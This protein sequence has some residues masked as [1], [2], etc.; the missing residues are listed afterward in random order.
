MTVQLA[1]A[2]GARVIGTASETGH[3]Y[4]RQ[5]GA[6]PVAYGDGL[7]D[8]VRDLAPG[9]VDAAIDTVGTD[10][11]IDVSVALVADRDRIATLAA[12]R[13]GLELGLRVL[14]GAPGADPGIEVRQAARLRAGAPGRGGNPLGAGGGHLPAGLGG[15]RPP[16]AGR[17]P[18]PRED[19]P[20]PLRPEPGRDGARRRRAPRCRRRPKLCCRDPPGPAVP[21]AAPA[22]GPAR[23]GA[24]AHRALAGG[25]PPRRGRP[26]GGH[27]RGV[28]SER[29]PAPDLRGGGHPPWPPG[30]RA[31]RRPAAPVGQAGQ[32]GRAGHP[33]AVVV[34][35][36]VRAPRRH[37]PAGRRGTAGPRRAGPGPG[38]E[39]ARR[40]RRPDHPAEP[41]RHPRR[42]RLPGGVRGPRDL[43]CPPDAVRPGPGRHGGLRRRPA[44]GLAARCPIQ[45]LRAGP[46]S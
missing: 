46:A 35:R 23:R 37:R 16:P 31:L 45:L 19:R 34:H 2:D 36:Q 38:V 7:L 10:E 44:A 20:H 25:T 8:R 28:R 1:V 14:G 43:R 15:R 39:C 21:P 40:S 27:G 42:P 13:R 30:V 29:P 22:P 9:G 24:V 5:L 41:A 26:E 3:A 11:A 17:R 12:A 33:V 18:H 4:L 6:E 32:A